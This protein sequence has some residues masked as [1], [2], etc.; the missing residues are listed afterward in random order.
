MSALPRLLCYLDDRIAARD[1]LGVLLAAAA[2]AGPEVGI[3]AR[4][5]GGTADQLTRLA[6]RAVANAGPPAAAVFVTGR[7]DIARA[8]G[9]QGVILRTTDL[10]PGE[11]PA[12]LLRIASVHSVEEARH[13]IAEGADALVVG[14]IWESGSHPGRPGAGTGLISASAALGKPVYAIGGVTP[15]RAREA[16]AAGAFGV[17]AIRAVWESRRPY[18]AAGELLDAVRFG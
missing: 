5:P 4:M 14:T 11:V 15:E 12:S 9:A 7:F 1:D 17:A 10:P 13:A 16:A 18:Q 6:A 2:A 8:V 3:V